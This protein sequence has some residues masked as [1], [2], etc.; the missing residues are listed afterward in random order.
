MVVDEWCYN[1]EYIV[2]YI[3]V[4]DLIKLVKSKLLDDVLILSEFIVLF[5]F[6]LKNIYNN[7]LKFYKS[8][9]LFCMSIQIR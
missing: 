8:K 3:L 4:L 7:V 9:V 1:V 2:Y 5:L 6:V